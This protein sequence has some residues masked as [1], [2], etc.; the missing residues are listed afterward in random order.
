[1]GSKIGVLKIAAGRLGISYEEYLSKRAKGFKHCGLCRQWKQMERFDIDRS[2]GDGLA[3]ACIDCRRVKVRK[4][5]KI[6]PPSTKI[7]NQATNAVR[8]AID[9]GSMPKVDSLPCFDCGKPA[10]HYHHFLGYARTHWLD[11]RPLC[12]SCHIK[13][14]WE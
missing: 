6:V 13:C 7:L 4:Q 8:K 12:I 11:V 14:H 1:M 10:K 5:R 2:R 3:S 9:H